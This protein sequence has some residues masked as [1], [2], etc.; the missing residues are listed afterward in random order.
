MVQA[1]ANDDIEQQIIDD[2][3]RHGW[4]LVGIADDPQGPAFT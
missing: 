1:K 3:Q 2:V 4:H